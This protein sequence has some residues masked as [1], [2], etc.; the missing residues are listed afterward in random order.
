MMNERIRQ[1][2]NDAM[3]SVF[4]DD[5]EDY[6][7]MRGAI[8]HVIDTVIAE[9]AKTVK[10][11]LESAECCAAS[12]WRLLSAC[13]VMHASDYERANWEKA[14]ADLEDWRRVRDGVD[15]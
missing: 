7:S 11:R 6:A 1:L 8:E 10:R 3:G 13:Q 5:D 15:R 4:S 2:A 14:K 9:E 12:L